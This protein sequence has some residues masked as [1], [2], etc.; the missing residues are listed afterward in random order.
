MGPARAATPHKR[1]TLHVWCQVSDVGLALVV[2]FLFRPRESSPFVEEDTAGVLREAAGNV[3]A[4]RGR[5]SAPTDDDLAR[6]IAQLQERA[7][8]VAP[9]GGDSRLQMQLPVL[10]ENPCGFDTSGR[11]VMSVSVGLPHAHKPD[12]GVTSEPDAATSGAATASEAPPPVEAPAVVD[13]PPLRWQQLHA[14]AGLA[15]AGAEFLNPLWERRLT[16]T[17]PAERDAAAAAADRFRMAWGAPVSR[18][19]EDTER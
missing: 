10:V 8:S 6:A 9:S 4:G 16:Q 13:P 19:S 5:L 2:A 17:E 11:Q 18:A 12:D 1:L 14:T 15:P 3:I 7:S